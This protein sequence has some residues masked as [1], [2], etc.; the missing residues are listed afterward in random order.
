MGLDLLDRRGD[1]DAGRGQ[2]PF[3]GLLPREVRGADSAPVLSPSLVRYNGSEPRLTRS[4]P[5]V[6]AIVRLLI[7]LGKTKGPDPRGRGSPTGPALSFPSQPGCT[8]GAWNPGRYLWRGV[9]YN[10][11]GPV[12]PSPTASAPTA[13]GDLRRA[14][15]RR[16]DLGADEGLHRFHQRVRRH[17]GVDERGHVRPAPLALLGSIQA[18]E[19]RR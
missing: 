11:W 8:P 13:P 2:D 3:C 17:A 15:R 7:G 9:D 12:K 1:R 10:G 14:P 4:S 19:I 16:L 18:S 6:R 5:R